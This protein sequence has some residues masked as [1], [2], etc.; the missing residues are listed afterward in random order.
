MNENEAGQAGRQAAEPAALQSGRARGRT[1]EEGGTPGCVLMSL[2][3]EEGAG[4]GS[5][6]TTMIPHSYVSFKI[7]SSDNHH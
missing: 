6:K 7:S 1:E 3:T 4:N 5:R 2:Q